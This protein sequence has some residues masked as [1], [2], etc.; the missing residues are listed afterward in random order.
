MLPHEKVPSG[1]RE[2]MLDLTGRCSQQLCVHVTPQNPPLEGY[3]SEMRR[4]FWCVFCCIFAA[5]FAARHLCRK[6]GG[7]NRQHSVAGKA[8]QESS[9]RRDRHLH[10]RFRQRFL[11]EVVLHPVLVHR[12]M[13]K[14]FKAGKTTCQKR[15]KNC[16]KRVAL[17][18]THF[19][20]Y[21][22]SHIHTHTRTPPRYY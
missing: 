20:A 4:R 9:V 11:E 1:F 17:E 21:I 3:F 6:V 5:Y 13:S 2:E 19:L 7:H 14:H 16:P 18:R 12:F 10:D 22:H 8:R 15:V